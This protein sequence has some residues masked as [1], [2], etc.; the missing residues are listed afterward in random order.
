MQKKDNFKNLFLAGIGLEKLLDVY[1]KH[2]ELM[3]RPDDYEINESP[4]N[5]LGKGGSGFAFK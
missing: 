4:E 2:E 1:I 5:L 3:I